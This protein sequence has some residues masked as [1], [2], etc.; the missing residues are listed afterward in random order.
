[1]TVEN[2]RERGKTAARIISRAEQSGN[3][4]RKIDV[5]SEAEVMCVFRPTF[6]KRSYTDDNAVKRFPVQP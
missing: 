5:R 2:R 4:I 3:E 1:M 6:R